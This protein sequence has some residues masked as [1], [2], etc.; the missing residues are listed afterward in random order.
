M[1]LSGDVLREKSVGSD[2]AGRIDI[3]SKVIESSYP[4][5][6]VALA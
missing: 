3:V 5:A 4:K 1:N 2:P 6:V